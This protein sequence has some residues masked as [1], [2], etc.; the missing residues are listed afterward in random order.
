MGDRQLIYAGCDLGTISA[1]AVIIDDDKILAVS[2]LPYKS[3]PRQ[4]AVNVLENALA[5]AGLA[6][7]RITFCLSTGFGKKAVPYADGDIPELICLSRAVKTLNPDIRTV[8]DAG[9][10]S[11]KAFNMNR[12]GKVTASSANEK[13]ASGTGKF[14]EVMAQALEMPVEELSREALASADPLP[15]TSQCG[16]FAESE[17]ITH[18]NEGKDRLDIFAGI[19]L[20]VAGKVA[21]T[22]RRISLDDAVMLVGGMAKNKIV[23]RDIQKELNIA[24][25]S[26]DLDPQTVS[27]YGAALMARERAP[28]RG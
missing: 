22:V 15:I 21:G 11:I 1:K 23:V 2:V 12:E 4:A 5:D 8:I 24:F 17:V 7:E 13:C 26:Y 10:Q 27:A 19:S 25:A 9:G 16:V 3:L 14:M 28:H 20:S 18:V 6:K